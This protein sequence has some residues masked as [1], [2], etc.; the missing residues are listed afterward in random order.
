MLPTHQNKIDWGNEQNT[1]YQR[2]CPLQWR[3]MTEIDL[4]AGCAWIIH[5]RLQTR[6]VE[7][8]CDEFS[9]LVLADRYFGLHIVRQS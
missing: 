3:E 5:V 2:E 4:R 1:D 6:A 8:R 9:S 7:R